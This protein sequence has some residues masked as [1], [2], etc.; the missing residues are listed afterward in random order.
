MAQ[1]EPRTPCCSSPGQA[2]SPRNPALGP[3]HRLQPHQ[4]RSR[5]VTY[6]PS[7]LTSSMDQEGSFPAFY[8]LEVPV[9]G[10]QGR[11][12]GYIPPCWGTCPSLPSYPTQNRQVTFVG[13]VCVCAKVT[14]G[15]QPG[16]SFSPLPAGDRSQALVRP[17]VGVS[18][19][20]HWPWPHLCPHSQTTLLGRRGARCR[21]RQAG[22]QVSP[23]LPPPAVTAAEPGPLSRA[24]G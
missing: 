18:A 12:L 13:A 19:G 23:A 7:S 1:D 15:R 4:E 5:Q 21:M 2:F 9:H 20:G 11:E 6:T 24:R 8:K 14:R 17:E 3:L 16:P 10:F 22:A